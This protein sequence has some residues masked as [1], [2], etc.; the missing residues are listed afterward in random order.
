[1]RR[2]VG[3]APLV[4][5]MLACPGSEDQPGVVDLDVIDADQ[6][7]YGVQRNLGVEG[8]RE[9]RLQA[10]SM[11]MWED[12]SH[13]HIEG[14]HL[15]I[16]T[17][18]GRLRATINSQRGR[19]SAGTSELISN[20]NVVLVIAEE[21]REIRSEEL[22]FAPETDRIWT[23]SAF[24]MTADDCTVSGTRLTADMEFRSWQV[25]GTKQTCPRN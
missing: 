14:L 22:R 3:L 2:M 15:T 8:V 11:F 1:M 21:N 13:V 7:L 5:I 6:V 4:L 18:E 23:D 10:D 19:L 9:A 16:F 20:G 12:S 17:T 24:T 25:W